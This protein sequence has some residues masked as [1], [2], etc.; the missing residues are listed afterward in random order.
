MPASSLHTFANSASSEITNYISY[1]LLSMRFTANY[2]LI[3]QPLTLRSNELY[4][5]S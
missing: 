1:R 3:L 4:T 2:E 5:Q